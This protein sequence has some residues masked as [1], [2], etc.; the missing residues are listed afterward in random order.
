MKLY[1]YTPRDYSIVAVIN[2]ESQAACERK[3]RQLNYDDEIY[4]STFS[5][6]FGTTEGLRENPQAEHIEA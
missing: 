4:E 5:P 1:V 3:A 6:R 2:G